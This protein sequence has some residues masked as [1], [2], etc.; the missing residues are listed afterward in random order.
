MGRV[1]QLSVSRGGVPKLPITEARVR[2]YGIEGDRQRWKKIHGGPRRALCLFSADVIDELRAE[3]HPITAGAT[4]EN[5]TIA[6]LDWST[7]GSGTRLSIGEVIAEVTL[8][9]DPCKQIAASFLGRDFRR[10]DAA[11]GV[12]RWYARVVREGLIRVGD[13]VAVSG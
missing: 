8:A 1:V 11:R 13:P 6:G 9:A 7:I 3:G 10:I 12:T 5:V 2:T 4:G